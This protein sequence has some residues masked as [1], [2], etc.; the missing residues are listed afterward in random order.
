ME[1]KHLSVGEKMVVRKK[2]SGIL[3]L[4]L[5]KFRFWTFPG[6]QEDQKTAE[7]KK[8]TLGLGGKKNVGW[9][10]KLLVGKEKLLFKKMLSVGNKI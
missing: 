6:M 5:E 4:D 7:A 10:N 1:K 2:F 8:K 3:G 9:K